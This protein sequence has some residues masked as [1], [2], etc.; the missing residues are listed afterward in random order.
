MLRAR[1]AGFIDAV[2]TAPLLPAGRTRVDI[3]LTP[4]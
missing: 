1:H 4:L 3:P 2:V